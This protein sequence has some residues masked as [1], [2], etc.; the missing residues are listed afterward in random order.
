VP[1]HVDDQ[2]DAVAGDAIQFRWDYT[3]TVPLWDEDGLL[4]EEPEWLRR[5]LG[6]S[7][8]MIERLTR[9]GEAMKAQDG[10]PHPGSL[11]SRAVRE[12]LRRRGRALSN[13]LQ[14]ELG[15]RYPVTY[16]PW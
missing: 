10:N 5:A 8:R 1:D 3:V 6:L 13:E 2:D 9:W 14:R 16:R 15:G 7:E 4:P 11:E 12:D